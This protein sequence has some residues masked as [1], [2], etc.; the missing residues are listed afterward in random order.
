LAKLKNSSVVLQQ[1]QQQVADGG[2]D[3]SNSDIQLV[4]V[5]SMHLLRQCRMRM[6]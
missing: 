3:G 5:A 6:Q 2:R 4:V 1:Q